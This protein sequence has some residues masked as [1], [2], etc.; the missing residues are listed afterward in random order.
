LKFLGDKTISETTSKEVKA[1]LERCH[2][3]A[4]QG[5]FASHDAHL[6]PKKIIDEREGF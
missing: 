3:P 4:L 1:P 6:P 2:C 5:V